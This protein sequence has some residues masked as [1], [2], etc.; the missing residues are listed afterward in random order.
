MQCWPHSYYNVMSFP[1][2]VYY[3]LSGRSQFPKTTQ[4]SIL[5]CVL[6]KL[7][8]WGRKETARNLMSDVNFLS[9]SWFMR[10]WRALVGYHLRLLALFDLRF[11][12]GQAVY[13]GENK[14]EGRET[15]KASAC[16]TDCVSLMKGSC[17]LPLISF[18]ICSM[19]LWSYLL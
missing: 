9:E 5:E 4:Q 2:F 11:I 18:S 3:M 6:A 12:C 10:L 1:E 8:L 16:V 17:T 19:R 13:V 7:I 14:R 15:Y